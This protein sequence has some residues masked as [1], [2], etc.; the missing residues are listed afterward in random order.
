M[1]INSLKTNTLPRTCW[2]C[3]KTVRLDDCSVD[4][5]GRAVHKGCY[6]AKVTR[7]SSR[8]LEST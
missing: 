4:E 6:V 1:L 8:P 7:P 2:M 5:Q 3:G